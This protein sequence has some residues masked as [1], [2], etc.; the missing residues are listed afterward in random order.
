MS[1]DEDNIQNNAH[2]LNPKDLSDKVRR[3]QV[4]RLTRSI[5]ATINN[6]MLKQGEDHPSKIKTPTNCYEALH[7]DNLY[8]EEWLKAI[9]KEMET[10]LQLG[11]FDEVSVEKAIKLKPLNPELCSKSRSKVMVRLSSKQ[12]S[13]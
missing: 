3:K 2:H 5:A 9:N 11:V 4:K 10:I 1:R 6:Y 12:D 8:R 13:W 7:E